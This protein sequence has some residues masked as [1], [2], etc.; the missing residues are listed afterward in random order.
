MEDWPLA[1]R[2]SMSANLAIL[3]LATRYPDDA[4]KSKE[5]S[6]VAEH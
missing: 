5:R 6:N 3:A 1:R 4:K 2:E